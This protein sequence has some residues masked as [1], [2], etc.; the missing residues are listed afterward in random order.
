M[1]KTEFTLRQATRY[2]DSRGKRLPSLKE[3]GELVVDKSQPENSGNLRA[4]LARHMDF[5]NARTFFIATSVLENK[6]HVLN[7]STESEPSGDVLATF[8]IKADAE[9]VFSVVCVQELK[10]AEDADGDLVPDTSDQCTRKTDTP[11]LTKSHN[12]PVRAYTNATYLDPKGKIVNHRG[13]LPGQHRDAYLDQ[14]D[15]YEKQVALAKERETL[16]QAKKG[17]TAQ[18]TAVP[19]P[20]K[21]VVN[22]PTKQPAKPAKPAARDDY[23]TVDLRG[24]GGAPKT[25]YVPGQGYL[26]YSEGV[27]KDGPYMQNVEGKWRLNPL[28]TN[29]K[30]F[31]PEAELNAIAKQRGLRSWKDLY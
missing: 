25:F 20:S 14:L 28:N 29:G 16:E 2:C 18:K 8:D 15:L 24:R 3:L 11:F 21:T 5:I 9:R 19:T 10:P 12:L 30:S 7:L 6:F 17:Q 23:E 27:D 22:E 13:C 4:Y 26:P 1:T 31:R